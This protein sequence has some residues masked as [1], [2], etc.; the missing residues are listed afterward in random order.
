MS[1]G[2]VK[3]LEMMYNSDMG[4]DEAMEILN[5]LEE[6]LRCL[7]S[8]ERRGTFQEKTMKK[9]F[10]MNTHKYKYLMGYINQ[11]LHEHK[12]DPIFTDPDSYE[13]SAFEYYIYYKPHERNK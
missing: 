6:E 1:E 11:K 3:I 5:I 4:K 12:I 7:D 13:K 10:D 9:V 2:S 8:Y